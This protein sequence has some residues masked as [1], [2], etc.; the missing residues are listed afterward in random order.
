MREI[1]FRVWNKCTKKYDYDFVVWEGK[2][3]I[4]EYGDLNLN[5]CWGDLEQFTGL[6][7]KNGKEIYEGDVVKVVC[8]WS[9]ISFGK[10]NFNET[11][12]YQIEY[13]NLKL[14]AKLLGS[15]FKENEM[16]SYPFDI[17]EPIYHDLIDL[18]NDLEIIGNIHDKGE[19]K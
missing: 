18:G 7:D 14:M 5:S 13:H 11:R 17:A 3:C 1:K 9:L 15:G 12:H 19:V 10:E 8:D 2:P 6:H 4:N 16:T